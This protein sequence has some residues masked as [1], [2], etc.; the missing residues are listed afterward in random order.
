MIQIECI[1]VL[2][3]I[4]DP[5]GGPGPWGEIRIVHLEKFQVNYFVCRFSEQKSV[6]VQKPQLCNVQYVFDPGKWFQFS[7]RRFS[8]LLIIQS[9]QI[10]QPLTFR[11]RHS[12]LGMYTKTWSHPIYS[13][14][15]QVLNLFIHRVRFYSQ[16]HVFNIFA[17]DINFQ[18]NFLISG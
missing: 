17:H 1:S 12:K 6:L 11:P 13:S 16:Y 5:S 14:K 18:I 10:L 8:I 7:L 4:S 2:W 9:K 15:Y 3:Y